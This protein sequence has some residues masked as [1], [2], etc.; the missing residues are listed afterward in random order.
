MDAH[1]HTCPTCGQKLPADAG[2]MQ[3]AIAGA[4]MG[5]PGFAGVEVQEDQDHD[6]DPIWSITVL[7]RRRS[8]FAAELARDARRF[9]FA[10][11]THRFPIVRV[12][13]PKAGR[14]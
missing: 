3:Q 9:A 1:P 14:P 8:R 13:H 7:V 5:R 2:A 12:A 4:L 10:T 6:G 11:D